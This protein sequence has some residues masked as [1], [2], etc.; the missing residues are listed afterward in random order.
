[1]TKR[2]QDKEEAENDAPD[3]NHVDDPYFIAEMALTLL[4]IV[5]I[6]QTCIATC[7]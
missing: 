4:P 3:N 5:K 1:M 6:D 2:K 7:L